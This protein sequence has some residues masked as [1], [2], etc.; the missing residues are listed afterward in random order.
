[1]G[2]R[3]SVERV[4]LG[5]SRLYATAKVATVEAGRDEQPDA[6]LQSVRG[7]H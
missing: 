2:T 4:R 7:T 3:L 1:M 6:Q 5:A